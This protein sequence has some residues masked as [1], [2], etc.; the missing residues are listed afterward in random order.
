MGFGGGF[1]GIGGPGGGGRPWGVGGFVFDGDFDDAT[2]LGKGC[3]FGIGRVVEHHDE[4]G[5]AAA[6][7]E[8]ACGE[9]GEDLTEG[10]FFGCGG[11]VGIH[12]CLHE[13]RLR[14]VANYVVDRRVERLR[15]G[16]RGRGG[17]GNGPG[18]RS[19]TTCG[20]LANTTVCRFGC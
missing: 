18:R 8:D 6:G 2:L 14:T 16:L 10:P 1:C 15:V 5:E 3:G 19:V 20:V 4:A 7:D 13:Q 12:L 9:K 11:G 17:R